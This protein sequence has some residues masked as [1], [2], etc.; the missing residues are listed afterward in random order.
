M[1]LKPLL[2]TLALS[3]TTLHAQTPPDAYDALNVLIEA[4]RRG[5]A[6]RE[7][8]F[9]ALSDGGRWKTVQFGEFEFSADRRPGDVTLL[10]VTVKNGAYV[11]A[12]AS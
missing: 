12:E 6:T 5:G 11:P 9:K 8:V 2:F 4:V 3:M 7:G 1:N 10:P